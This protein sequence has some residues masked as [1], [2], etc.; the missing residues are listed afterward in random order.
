MK[1]LAVINALPTSP[2]ERSK[3]PLR[4]LV[5][6]WDEVTRARK[7]AVAVLDEIFDESAYGRFL[8]RNQLTP[9]RENYAA[10]RTEHEHS[11]MRRPRCC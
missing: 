2:P 1:R 7:L 10:F 6:L 4:S 11:K 8:A 9:S 3:G 5:A